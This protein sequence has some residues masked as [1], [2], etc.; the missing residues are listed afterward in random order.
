M[1]NMK[2]LLSLLG[3]GAVTVS[4][5]SFTS[6]NIFLGHK[7][8]I[9]YQENNQIDWKML[10]QDIN[11]YFN[12]LKEAN[13]FSASDVDNSTMTLALDFA[14]Q[15]ANDYLQRFQAQNLSLEE[16]I[17]TLGQE[18][19][20]FAKNYQEHLDQPVTSDDSFDTASMISAFSNSEV[21]VAFL[22]KKIKDLKIA[23]TVF[24]TVSATSAVA[25]AGFW[26]AAWFFGISV[27]WAISATLVSAITGTVA[28]GLNI[29]IVKYDQELDKWNK[30][31]RTTPSTITLGLSFYKILKPL[32]SLL[33][34][35]E[36][37]VVANS[38]KI[39]TALAVLP[40]ISATLAFINL[41]K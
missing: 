31:E 36:V 33:K 38:W 18:S 41:L 39:P 11:S 30:V 3:V 34:T 8:E 5:V 35:A 23:Q 29:S 20:E 16:I 25:A 9:S 4:A 37:T 28:A 22:D 6:S 27:P 13:A 15:K 32:L 12:N 19:P 1:K 40:V 7:S 2:I 10:N 26:A 17:K 24:I 14:Q 21:S